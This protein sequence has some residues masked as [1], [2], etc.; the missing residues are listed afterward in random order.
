MFKALRTIPVMLDIA[1]DVESICP[2]AWMINYANPT[3]MNAEAV[4]KYTGAKFVGLCSG[5][6]FPRDAVVKTLGVRPEQVSY[7][8]FGLNHLNFGYNLCV[9]GRPLTESEFD[10][11]A[12]QSAVDANLVRMLGLFPSPYLQYFFHRAHKVAEAREKTTTRGED[13]QALEA[14]IFAAYADPSQHT[15]PAALAK[16]GGGGYSEIA[17]GVINAIHNDTREVIIVNTAQ[18]GVYPWLPADAVLEL[19][20]LVSAAGIRPLAQPETP[21]PVWGL[22]AAVKNYERLAVE[23]AVSGDRALA[24]AAL[25]AHPLVGDVDVARELLDEMLEANREYLPAFFQAK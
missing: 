5:G 18:Q 17:L 10:Q 25:L 7:D 12:R 14:E 21:K 23:A 16:R 24:L 19:P 8:Y 1:R 3:G 6:Y 2:Q 9:S 22:V 13:V 20:C 15:K 4:L 11:V